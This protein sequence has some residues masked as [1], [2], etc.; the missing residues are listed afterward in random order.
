MEYWAMRDRRLYDATPSAFT[1]SISR[2]PVVGCRTTTPTWSHSLRVN[3][4]WNHTARQPVMQ[5]H[6]STHT[7]NT[8][9]VAKTTAYSEREHNP[10]AA[11]T[12]QY[13]QATRHRHA[14]EEEE[15][16]GLDKVVQRRDVP[17]EACCRQ[18]YDAAA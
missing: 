13:L 10:S 2:S 12:A 11:G 5:R 8:Q 4:R 3:T 6:S 7:H 1:S 16:A 14:R 9:H 15:I 17:H 18:A